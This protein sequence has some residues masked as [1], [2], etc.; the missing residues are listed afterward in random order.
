MVK[1]GKPYVARLHEQ[2]K[3]HNP[4]SKM[5]LRF[6]TKLTL[7]CVFWL[8]FQVSAKAGELIGRAILN[9]D[10]FAVGSTSGQFKQTQRSLPFHHAQPVQGFSSVEPGPRPGTYFV[11][12]DNGFG[13]KA[14]SP[15]YHLRIYAVEPDFRNGQVY[16]IHV[17]TGD[18]LPRFNH[19]SFI[20][21]RDSQRQISWGI[22][23]DSPNYPQSQIPVSPWIRNQRVLTGGDFD[24]ES[25]RRVK[26]GFWVGDEFG[27]FL[28]H[29]DPRGELLQPPIPIPNLTQVGTATTI[30]SPDHPDFVNLS[31]EQR[32]QQANL[33]GSGGL[34]GMAINPAGTKLYLMLEKTLVGDKPK[35]LLIYE[36]DL[37]EQKFTGQVFQYQLEQPHYAI[38]EI[39]AINDREFLVIERDHRQG[40]PNHPGFKQPAQFKRIY[41]INLNQRDGDG[42]VSKE[43]LVDLLKI[44][45]PRGIG[46]RATKNGI[47]TF[48]FV[49]IES[50]LPIDRR[51]L[52]VI[53]DNNYADSVGRDPKQVDNTEFILI[54]LR[55]D[56]DLEVGK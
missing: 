53:N 2:S 16:P 24:P 29:F 8:L 5:V 34:E 20:E 41:K 1:I 38:G 3:I 9:A 13:S 45:D 25:F 44:A 49:T 46:G 26:S 51:T 11:L 32:Q 54:R 43:L 50:V 22:I 21:F 14:N 10:T 17:K 37:T 33:P 35:R 18:R 48:P 4:K 28:L 42:Y 39:T 7:A 27:P 19:D 23:A 52:L 6:P 36:F 47:F 56:L 55:Q 40:D 15:D 31:R 12:S 30:R